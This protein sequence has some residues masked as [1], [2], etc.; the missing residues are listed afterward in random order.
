MRLLDYWNKVD[1]KVSILIS[2]AFRWTFKMTAKNLGKLGL[3]P[4]LKSPTIAW[5]KYPY[6]KQTQLKT[7]NDYGE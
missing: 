5:L 3:T 6:G 1:S 7:R 2:A 4:N